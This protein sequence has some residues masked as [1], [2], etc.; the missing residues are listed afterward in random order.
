MTGTAESYA[1][2]GGYG[3]QASAVLGWLLQA[4][5][6][7]QMQAT[8]ELGVS[9]LAAVIHDLRNDGFIFHVDRVSV[10]NRYQKTS[11]V[12][13]YRLTGLPSGFTAPEHVRHLW[14]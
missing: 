12:A 13:V 2:L 1:K 7:S 3:P 8:N 6:L 4:K 9:R 14:K 11:Q 10:P 5:P